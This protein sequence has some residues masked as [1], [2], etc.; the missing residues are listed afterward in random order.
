M[1]WAIV[2]LVLAEIGLNCVMLWLLHGH[3][4]AMQAIQQSLRVWEAPE[5]L[6]SPYLPA[7]TTFVPSDREAAR[8]EQEWLTE[9]RQR[10]PALRGSGQSRSNSAAKTG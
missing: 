6:A 2:L 5:K 1:L 4:V 7:G 10:T 9:S 3:L 8:R